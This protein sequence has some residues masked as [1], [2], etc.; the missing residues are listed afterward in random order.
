MACTI[1]ELKKS[2]CLELIKISKDEWKDNIRAVAS[3]LH[4]KQSGV[5]RCLVAEENDVIVGFIYAFVLPN[6]TLIPELLYVQPEHRKTGIGHSLLAALEKKSGCNCSMIFY[7]KTLRNYYQ[8]QG[9]K[10]GE[11]LEVAMKMLPA[12][13]SE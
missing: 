6:G 10:V 8:R 5:L 1:R 13:E 11:N 12:E 3:I 9:Y 2:D 4:R 7:H